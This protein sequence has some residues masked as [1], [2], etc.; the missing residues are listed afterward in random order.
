M[1]TEPRTVADNTTTAGDSFA[2]G[3][4]DDGYISAA[5]AAKLAVYWINEAAFPHG[6]RLTKCAADT[7]NGE[8][9]VT[10][11]TETYRPDSRNPSTVALCDWGGSMSFTEPV[12]VG[13]LRRKVW[14]EVFLAC[15]RDIVHEYA[16]QLRVANLSADPHADD[17]PVTMGDLE[18]WENVVTADLETL[19]DRLR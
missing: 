6:T 5:T 2:S 12:Q 13:A 8:S 17:V 1:A 19:A 3:E 10:W 7:D 4:F 15:V 18:P 14:C 11:N 9:T 16:E